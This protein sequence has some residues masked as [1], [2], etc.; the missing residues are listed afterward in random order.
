MKPSFI[1]LSFLTATSAIAADPV[2]HQQ[3]VRMITSGGDISSPRQVLPVAREIM[4]TEE[5]DAQQ[6]AARLLGRAEPNGP[7]QVGARVRIVVTYPGD[8][9]AYAAR[10]LGGSERAISDAVEFNQLAGESKAAQ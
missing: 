8:A 6:K 9:H 5:T 4:V 7:S 3:A 2:G 1:L 10:L